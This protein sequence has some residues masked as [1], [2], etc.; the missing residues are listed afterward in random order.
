MCQRLRCVLATAYLK[1]GR[2]GCGPRALMVPLAVLASGAFASPSFESS[3]LRMAC[4]GGYRR[5]VQLIGFLYRSVRQARG[6]VKAA[7]GVLHIFSGPRGG[8][9]LTPP[10]AWVGGA[11]AYQVAVYS[12][13]TLFCG[14]GDVCGFA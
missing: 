2:V 12:V 7:G 9:F 13:V 4:R 11:A 8:Q 3:C 5:P 10:T 14:L 6:R 1:C